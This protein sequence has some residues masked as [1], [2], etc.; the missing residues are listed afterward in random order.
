MRFE[1]RT[2]KTA[3]S[4]NADDIWFALRTSKLET[5]SYWPLGKPGATSENRRKGG[6]TP[7]RGDPMEE[8][9]TGMWK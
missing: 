9:M 8:K 3:E 7:G 1:A 5:V 6:Y 4:F 2:F